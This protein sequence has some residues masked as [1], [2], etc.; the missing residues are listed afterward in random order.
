MPKWQMP[1]WSWWAVVT[2][3]SIMYLAFDPCMS[4]A[5]MFFMLAIGLSLLVDAVFDFRR[6]MD[7][8]AEGKE[9]DLAEPFASL[10]GPQLRMLK[11]AIAKRENIDSLLAA[12]KKQLA[13]RTGERE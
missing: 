1:K 5:E 7:A 9:D 6:I 2:G 8:I 3:L 13:K 10:T 4:Q 11:S 12:L